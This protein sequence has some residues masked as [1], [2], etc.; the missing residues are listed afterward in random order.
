VIIVSLALDVAYFTARRSWSRSSTH[1]VTPAA[2]R[3]VLRPRALDD[4][5]AGAAS[6]EPQARNGPSCTRSPLSMF[7]EGLTFTSER[8][9]DGARQIWRIEGT[10]DLGT[11]TTA[12]F[13]LSR[14]PGPPPSSDEPPHNPPKSAQTSARFRNCLRPRR[15]SNHAIVSIGAGRRQS[16][17][18]FTSD[19]LSPDG[20]DLAHTL[21]RRG[22]RAA[23]CVS[24][25]RAEVYSD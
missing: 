8:T 3:R 9:P 1:I 21:G 5:R 7:P 10:A 18:P 19:R 2:I 22:S 11:A 15:D 24:V 16:D 17:C 25:D 4:L 13:R 12:R 20:A 14:N 6:T 23:L